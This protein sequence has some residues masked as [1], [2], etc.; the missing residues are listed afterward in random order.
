MDPEVRLLWAV[1]KLP[2]LRVFAYVVPTSWTVLPA[3]SHRSGHST[4]LPPRWAFPVPRSP[5]YV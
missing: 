3:T 5:S 4:K 1:E 2:L